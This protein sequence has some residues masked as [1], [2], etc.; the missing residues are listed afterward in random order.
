MQILELSH[1]PCYVDVPERAISTG[2]ARFLHT[3]EV[4][5][6]NPVSPI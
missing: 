3:E 6:S 2:V 5:G 1:D 4:T